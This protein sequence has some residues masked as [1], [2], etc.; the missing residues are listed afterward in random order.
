MIRNPDRLRR[1]DVRWEREAYADLSFTEALEIYAELWRHALRL[2]PD[3]LAGW[4]HDLVPDLAIARAVN[5]L[6]P[7]A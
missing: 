2:N 6:P 7:Q 5:G 1:L 4:R 3:P